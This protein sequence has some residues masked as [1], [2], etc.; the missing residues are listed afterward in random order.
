LWCVFRSWQQSRDWD[1]LY[2]SISGLQC[3]NTSEDGE[4]QHDEAQSE[5]Q[6]WW[7]VLWAFTR[8]NGSE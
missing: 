2:A 7:A 3:T 5:P 6:A 8:R 1:W 4:S